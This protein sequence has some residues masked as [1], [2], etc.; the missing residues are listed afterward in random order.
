VYVAYSRFMGLGN[1]V[2][3]TMERV[4]LNKAP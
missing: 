2:T 1:Q 3:L 4:T